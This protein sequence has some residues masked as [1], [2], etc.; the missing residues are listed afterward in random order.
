MLVALLPTAAARAQ[1]TVAF[2][3]SD[4]GRLNEQSRRA[5][6]RVLEAIMDFRQAS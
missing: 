2:P 1:R 3:A 5:Q 4:G 6:A